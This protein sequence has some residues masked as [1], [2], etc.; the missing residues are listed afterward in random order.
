MRPHVRADPPV[1]SSLAALTVGADFL[2]ARG[3]S[4]S[5]KPLLL[6][7]AL[8]TEYLASLLQR[9]LPAPDA[10]VP[11]VQLS[12][13]QT[14]DLLQSR[15]NLL[16]KQRGD[17][18]RADGGLAVAHSVV[19]WQLRT[20][21][22]GKTASGASGGKEDEGASLPTIAEV[23]AAY[24][25]TSSRATAAIAAQN[26]S[27]ALKDAAWQAYR[28]A[29]RSAAAVEIKGRRRPQTAYYE[30]PAVYASNVHGQLST[31][32]QRLARGAR[33]QAAATEPPAGDPGSGGE[34]GGS[35]SLV[36][37]PGREAAMSPGGA[38]G[39]GDGGGVPAPNRAQAA[40]FA[41]LLADPH[42][43]VGAPHRATLPKRITQPVVLRPSTAPVGSGGGGS[44]KPGAG[45]KLK[46]APLV[47]WWLAPDAAG[48]GGGPPPA[49]PPS[50]VAVFHASPAAAVLAASGKILERFKK[51][52]EEDA[53]R[54]MA[55]AA[56][57]GV[58]VVGAPGAEA[59]A[60]GDKACKAMK[61]PPLSD[62]S[63][64]LR[65]ATSAGGRRGASDG[66]AAARPPSAPAAP[67]PPPAAEGDA[68]APPPL[69]PQFIGGMYSLHPLDAEAQREDLRQRILR[70]LAKK[71]KEAAALA[72]TGGDKK[73]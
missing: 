5:G 8:Q 59:G 73:K 23:A 14:R 17:G 53:A 39:F 55:A 33:H 40:A 10:A 62:L 28:A 47:D 51:D 54:V 19:H 63:H 36:G 58:P 2:R 16:S 27:A 48:G 69:P 21:D 26:G 60:A 56:K 46:R 49:V 65:P 29:Q 18:G 57:L 41:A 72:K 66:G 52:S 11:S 45:A 38:G 12:A 61:L 22:A 13:Y 35:S 67:P 6:S 31:L 71:A 50:S 70:D 42:A 30:R 3:S 20:R 34:G 1:P 25:S 32:Q 64:A 9:Q 44:G 68:E 7:G 4:A 24:G 37:S 43:V 15:S